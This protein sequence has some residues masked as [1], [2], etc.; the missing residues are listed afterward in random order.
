M[1]KRVHRFVVTAVVAAVLV[2]M[3]SAVRDQG[4]WAASSSVLYPAGD[5]DGDGLNDVVEG[6]YVSSPPSIAAR[7][8]TDGAVLWRVTTQTGLG[9][10]PMIGAGGKGAVLAQIS[11]AASSYLP[12][13]SIYNSA[14]VLTLLGSDGKPRWTRP[15]PATVNEPHADRTDTIY[16]GVTV[17]KPRGVHGSDLVLTTRVTD[18]RSIVE[19]VDG[20][21]G[22]T[23][24][25][26]VVT[27]FGFKDVV[28]LPDLTGDGAGDFALVGPAGD[29]AMHDGVTAQLR[30]RAIA[31]SNYPAIVL[32]GDTSGDGVPDL[33]VQHGP[34]GDPN[35]FSVGANVL[36]GAT[37]AI[38]WSTPDSGARN[39]IVGSAGDRNNDGRSD[40]RLVRYQ[41]SVQPRSAEYHAVTST[42]V[43]AE[44]VFVDT[45]PV[46]PPQAAGDV[47]ADGITDIYAIG[48]ATGGQSRVVVRSGASGLVLSD[49]TH[50]NAPEPL[51]ASIDGAG[52]D[53]MPF[54]R[55]DAFDGATQASL[56]V[57][58]ITRGYRFATHDVDG[59]GKSELIVNNVVR[60]A[61]DGSARWS[62]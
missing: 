38:L 61:S 32:V 60:R 7:R 11:V 26:V 16:G 54:N 19:V 48:S 56:W 28:P 21:T 30:W 4:A 44:P 50:S 27:N 53:F 17:L 15:G 9:A 20:T 34:Y 46:G 57:T 58:G 12:G 51:F 23:S 33:G 36:D 14:T 8:G 24:G 13:T 31:S 62:A 59:D 40:V 10:I 49:A 43:A 52:D 47:D 37:G 5:F 18:T 35:D 45:V 22:L 39:V 42:G 41:F 2:A 29:V 55:V 25:Q 6:D 3:P 1:G